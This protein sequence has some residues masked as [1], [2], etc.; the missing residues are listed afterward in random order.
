MAIAAPTNAI[1]PR[2]RCVESY[3]LQQRDGGPAIVFDRRH[4][5]KTIWAM[6]GAYRFKFDQAGE[7]QPKPEKNEASH[8]ADALQYLCLGATGTTA[9]QIARKLSRKTSQQPRMSA[10]GWT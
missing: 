2:L 8:Y 7:A 6:G 5:I 3:L 1:D 10:A 9:L 4:C